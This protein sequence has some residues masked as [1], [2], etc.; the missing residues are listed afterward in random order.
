M[1]IPQTFDTLSV[2]HWLP[3]KHHQ[4]DDF[5]TPMDCLFMAGGIVA[6]Q[7]GTCLAPRPPWHKSAQLS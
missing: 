2:L 7:F 3:G 1:P 5:D 6:G 4:Y